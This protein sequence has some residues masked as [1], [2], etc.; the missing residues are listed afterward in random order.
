MNN[1]ILIHAVANKDCISFK[2]MSRSRKSPHWFYV[3]RSKLAE[4]EHKS[5]IIVHDI[6]SFAILYRD[7]NTG[8]IE[9]EFTWLSGDVNNVS[10]YKETVILPYDKLMAFVYN[11]ATE[12]SPVT[13]KAL[14]IDNSRK[15]PKIVFK[16]SRN[17]HNVIADSTIRHKLVHS[18][19]DSFNWP[20]AEKIELY[21]DYIPYSFVFTEI[22]NGK[23]AISGGLV[24][25]GQDN[26]QKA[27]YSIH[28]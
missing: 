19:R 8:T 27:Y 26:M 9:I 18:L 2:T 14:S 12:G 4:L 25:H 15:C 20:S 17:L 3:L 28:T 11:S 10:G 13:W 21:D 16:S 24:L 5:K 6:N 1:R 22:K 7:S 23:P